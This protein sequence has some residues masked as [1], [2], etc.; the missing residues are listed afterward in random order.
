MARKTALHVLM[1][2]IEDDSY[3]NISLNHALIH[4]SLSTKDKD[5]VTNIVYGTVQ[6]KIYLNYLLEPF[7]E[8]KK[9]HRK[10]HMILLMSIYQFV[11]L[12]KI[13]DFAIVSEAVELASIRER[14]NGRFVNAILRSFIKTPLRSLDDLDDINKLAIE[15]SHPE[16]LVRLL[17]SQ[18][19]FNEATLIC[20]SN[21]AIP[22]RVG[23]VNTLK[24][25]VSD[26][27]KD[28]SFTS[29]NISDVAVCLDK[30][31]IANTKYYQDG[32]LTIQDESSQLVGPF[33]SP[34][35][36]SKVLDM[37]CAPGSKT[38][39]LSA[40]ME[41]T[42]EVVACDLFEHKMNLVKNNLSRLGVSNVTCH[43][44]DSTKLNT[45]FEK[46]TF[47]A[48]LLDAPCSGLGVMKRKPEIKY[49]DSGVMD[50]LI[51]LQTEL[52]ENAYIL[53]KKGGK[54]V[55]STCTI[56]KKEN[57]KMIQSFLSNHPDMEVIAQRLVLPYEFD[58]DGFYMC[59]L[60]KRN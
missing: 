33:L 31:N 2:Y 44:G 17:C 28:D 30:G 46:E 10:I 26:I 53:L 6:N 15:T 4:S 9:V 18:Y 42:G 22:L 36:N 60:Q 48:I 40:I 23:R 27:L 54:M 39:H 12:T 55:Y 5:L 52:L 38:A 3:L 34:D 37:C 57:E 45:V 51:P 43:V 58:S 25:S 8:G 16:W 1:K 11:F 56:N 7:I 24:T 21:N 35:K 41:N 13:P 29:G 59:K 19:D 32:L 49:H 14:N 20:K 47:D 50:K